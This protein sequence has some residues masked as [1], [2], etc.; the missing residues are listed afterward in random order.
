M[1]QQIKGVMV[2]YLDVGQMSPFKAELFLEKVKGQNIDL[3]YRLK[4]QGI[5]TLWIPL[6]PGSQTRV[7]MVPLSKD[8][9]PMIT[10]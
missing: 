8:C 10:D 5:E 2:F 6:R 9:M 1:E 3:V 4:E 7:E